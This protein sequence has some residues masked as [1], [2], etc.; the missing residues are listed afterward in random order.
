MVLLS[1]FERHQALST[2]MMVIIVSVV[3]VSAVWIAAYLW[4][5]P[6]NLKTEE[7]EFNDF[8][9]VK[10]ESAFNV[11]LPSQTRTALL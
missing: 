2:L 8:T 7:M 5:L 11:K 6:G 9:A 1:F 10:V 3:V 4:F